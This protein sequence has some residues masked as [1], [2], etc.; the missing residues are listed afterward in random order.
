M[1]GMPKPQGLSALRN[2]CAIAPSLNN[3]LVGVTTVFRFRQLKP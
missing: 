3:F 1:P 2:N